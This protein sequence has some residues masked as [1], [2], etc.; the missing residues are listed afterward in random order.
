MIF[1]SYFQ[2]NWTVDLETC[3]TNAISNYSLQSH[4][5]SLS[6]LSLLKLLNIKT[7][8]VW[9]VIFSNKWIPAVFFW[10]SFASQ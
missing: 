10:A 2:D 3:F 4:N 6:I 8:N 7:F 5:N 1:F 9:L